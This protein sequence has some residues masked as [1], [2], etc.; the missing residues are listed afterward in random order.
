MRFA[1]D[2]LAAFKATGKGGQTRVN[3]VMP[4]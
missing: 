3:N 1:P 2:V 4:I